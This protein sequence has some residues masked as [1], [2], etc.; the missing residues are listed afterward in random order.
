[1]DIA[2][3][4]KLISYRNKIFFALC[5]IKRILNGL[6]MVFFCFY[7]LSKRFEVLSSTLEF[8]V[9]FK[10]LLGI[11]TGCKRRIKRDRKIIS[12]I[13]I[14]D[15]YRLGRRLCAISIHIKKL[16]VY[17]VFIPFL[18][19]L[20]LLKLKVILSYSPFKSC[21]NDMSKVR[22]LL[23]DSCKGVL[24]SIIAFKKR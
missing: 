14:I 18:S 2:C 12:C 16:S 8:I 17:A 19:I 21:S 20:E 3:F 7:F 10:I 4:Y 15:S 5:Y 23:A 13:I 6:K 1:M 24:L 11:L 22:R 9:P